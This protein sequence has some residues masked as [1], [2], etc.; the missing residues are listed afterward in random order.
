MKPSSQDDFS[1]PSRDSGTQTNYQF[2]PVCGDARW[3]LY[4]DPMRGFWYCFSCEARGC[5]EISANRETWATTVLDHLAGKFSRMGAAHWPEMELPE[6]EPLSRKATRYLARRGIDADLARKLGIVERVGRL[7]IIIPYFGPDG[8]I[9]Y[10]T[11]RAY[12]NFEEGPKYLTAGGR[13]PLFVLP[14]WHQGDELVIVEGVLDAIMVHAHT[15]RRVVAL[16]GK[17][18]PVY[19]RPELLALAKDRIDIALDSDALAS[20]LTLKSKLPQHLDVRIVMLPDGEDPAS[21]GAGIKEWL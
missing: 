13:H 20:A 12:S 6:W 17:S 1:G 11:A 14:D 2:C 19:L 8:S 10:H 9:I 7:R 21:L 5:V 3:K 15:A 4:L 16:G 18:L